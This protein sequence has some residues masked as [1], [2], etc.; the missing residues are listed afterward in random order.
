MNRLLLALGVLTAGVILIPDIAEAQRGGRGGFG[1]GGAN[2]GQAQF[3]PNGAAVNYYLS[4]APSDRVTIDILDQS[5]KPIRSYSSEAT[6][7]QAGEAPA[8]APDDEE[9]GG[10]RR[11][12]PPVRL[13]AIAAVR[14]PPMPGAP[15]R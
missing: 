2:P 9:G 5:G 8:A 4:H 14:K 13:T 12:A 7:T 15:P 1:G 10:P 6:S 11:A 3:P